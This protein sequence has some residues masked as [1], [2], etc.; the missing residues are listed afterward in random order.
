MAEHA[1]HSRRAA[2]SGQLGAEAIATFLDSSSQNGQALLQWLHGLFT[3]LLFGTVMSVDLIH[4]AAELALALILC[5]EQP[6]QS[7]VSHALTT[8]LCCQG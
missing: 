5:Y 7:L 1:F 4:T 8:L 3:K 2:E 6:F